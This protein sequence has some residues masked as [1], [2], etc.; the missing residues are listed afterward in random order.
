MDNLFSSNMNLYE[1]LAE[2]MRPRT[3]DDF[4]GHEKIVGIGTLLRRIIEQ[5]ELVSMIFWAPPGTGKTT[6]ARVIAE[7]TKSRFISFSAVMGGVKQI[8]EIIDEAEDSLRLYRKRTVL[9]VDEIHRFNKSQQDLFLPFVEKGS[10]VLI[11]ATTENPSF[12]VNAALLSRC[13]VFKLNQL[14]AQHVADIVVRA[15]H[16]SERGYGNQKITI[17]DNTIRHI[18]VRANGDARAA[19]NMLEFA[20]KSAIRDESGVLI[21]DEDSVKEIIQ[22]NILY[23]KNGEEHYNIISAL[24]KS[25]RGSDINAS[26]YWMARMLEGGEDP[27]YIARRLIRFASEDIGLADPHALTQCVAVYQACHF[28]GAPECSVHLSQAVVYLARAPKSNA[29]Y[30][31]Y[32]SVKKD[33]HTTLT[34]SVPLHLCNA[35]TDLMKKIGYSKGYVYNPD[36]KGDVSQE[37]LPKKL[38]GKIYFEE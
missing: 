3:L 36:H 22:K 18:A 35:P 32:E 29:L 27:L 20:V 9:F 4:V 37:Y 25:L 12:E 33:V 19:L 31:A 11:G 5:D 28:L 24:H 16:D 14:G 7:L 21:I 34:E 38:L 1:P 30:K 2:R 6:L 17:S 26:L 15:I 23:D 10:L 8:R 13:R